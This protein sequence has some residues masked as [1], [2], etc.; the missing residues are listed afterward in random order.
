M[1]ERKWSQPEQ[2]PSDGWQEIRAGQPPER[3]RGGGATGLRT[4][5]QR[6]RTRANLL[7]VATAEVAEFGLSGA[8]VDQIARRTKTSKRMLYYY[9]GDKE[10]L[11]RAVLLSYY[12]KFRSAE[13]AL[14]LKC[15]PPLLALKTLVEFAF[16]FHLEHAN[17]ARLVMVENINKGRHMLKR[18]SV[19]PEDFAALDTVADIL[20]RGAQKGV[21][22]EDLDSLNLYA[23]IIALCFFNVSNRFTVK[24]VF[25]HD[26][27][28]A[29]AAAARKG[30][31]W[32]TI[33]RSVLA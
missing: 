1:T 14:N 9:F 8:R 28:D 3:H 2:A 30:V 31:V 32:E 23:S 10:G 16:D 25:C 6:G 11:Y 20:R 24:A 19:A 27:H 15:K 13:Q 5:R 17:V 21:M 33:K 4:A 29:M 7:R 12:E 22:R 18:S 26:M